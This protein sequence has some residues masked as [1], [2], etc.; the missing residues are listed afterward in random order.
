MLSK[1]KAPRRNVLGKYEGTNLL[2]FMGF[3]LVL[4][5]FVAWVFHSYKSRN[6]R[7]PR[8]MV[9]DGI[10]TEAVSEAS[11][12]CLFYLGT[13]LSETNHKYTGQKDIP[14]TDDGLVRDL[15]AISGVVEVTVDQRLIVLQKA[16]SAHWEAIQPGAREVIRNHLHLHK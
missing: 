11:G 1:S 15:F 10:V 7:P 16:P 6:D 9:D 8:T 5:V 13:K 3:I 2:F 14:I 12:T 4:G